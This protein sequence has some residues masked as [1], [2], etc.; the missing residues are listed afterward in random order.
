VKKNLKV[1][2]KN[3]QLAAAFNMGKKQ[4]KPKSGGQ[5]KGSASGFPRSS[6]SKHSGSQLSQ[7]EEPLHGKPSDVIPPCTQ[8]STQQGMQQQEKRNGP[9]PLPETTP[10][11]TGGLPGRPERSDI[12]SPKVESRAESG[13]GS[14]DGLR[15]DSGNRSEVGKRFSG[16]FG[17]DS[18]VA[19]RE[20]PRERQRMP[21]RGGVPQKRERRE[22]SGKATP[23]PFES[24]FKQRSGTLTPGRRDHQASSSFGG[25]N[26]NG[27]HFRERRV[28]ATGSPPDKVQSEQTG[29]EK[30]DPGRPKLGTIVRSAR[31][32]ANRAAAQK[33]VSGRGGRA[34]KI[35]PAQPGL[36][37]RPYPNK[38]GFKPGMPPGG[39]PVGHAN[40]RAGAR[41]D[42]RGGAKRGLFDEPNGSKSVGD[43]KKKGR[44][45][46]NWKMQ[47]MRHFRDFEDD[48]DSGFQKS[49]RRRKKNVPI[50]SAEQRVSRPQE[51][52]ISLPVS[53]KDLA[54]QMKVKASELISTLFLHG[55][56]YTINDS[57]H[58][59]LIVQFIGG[60]MNCDITIDTEKEEWMAI[61]KGSVKEE[62]R[63]TD[64]SM[65]EVRPAVVAMMGHVDHGK[66]TLI[67]ALRKSQI[68]QQEAGAITQHIGAFYVETGRGR[69]TV[70]DTPGHEAFIEMRS[71]GVLITDI[72]IL[73]IA[74]DEG[75]NQQTKEVIEKVKSSNIAC[76]VAVTKCDREGFDLN[77]IYE[78]LAQHELLVED[79]GGNILSV[80]CS[81]VTGEGL[82]QLV[83]AI[84]L[85]A[86]MLELLSQKDCRAR[87]IVFEAERDQGLGVCATLLVQNGTLRVRDS[88][89]VGQEWCRVKSMTSDTGVELGAAYPSMAVRVTGFSG[90][91]SVG[92]EFVAVSSVKEAKNISNA[93]RGEAAD[94]QLDRHQMRVLQDQGVKI[95]PLI[96]RGDVSGSVEAL[97][98]LI[99]EIPTEKVYAHIV[100]KGIGAISESD[101]ELAEIARA[102]II[103]FHVKCDHH[104]AKMAK[105]R[106]VDLHLYGI[107]YHAQDG[108]K[109]IM[110]S[111]LEPLRKETKT[112]VADVRRVFR[113]PKRGTVAGCVVRDGSVKRSS[114][115][116][117]FRKEEMLW[118]GKVLSMKREKEEISES[119]KGGECGILAEHFSN[120]EEG[121]V[122]E[123]YRETYEEQDL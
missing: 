5:D 105:E 123:A 56:S 39:R 98:H 14:K 101:I 37:R 106:E 3:T 59:P 13:T 78:Q 69:V 117:V 85:Q 53:V 40:V 47:S 29:Q 84:G 83:E 16:D 81:G 19:R 67:D 71:R 12:A 17:R 30:E 43:N 113:I 51:I 77:R 8:Q 108:V 75:I 94:H 15:V 116:K 95:L 82:D 74:G 36:P 120:F 58:D 104:L 88:F 66:T 122:I 110:R 111:L 118:E 24:S 27:Q 86:E 103:G 31:E 10:E 44:S 38:G 79:W 55:E 119:S 57:I 4:G 121:D 28:F 6:V 33:Q 97:C 93:R 52:S 80:P 73:V 41:S 32:E 11:V 65:L 46:P 48:S 54:G 89:V 21:Q 34:P 64:R 20:D 87:G 91:P 2:I 35:S 76:V 23:S 18:S 26:L 1:H 50:P 70:I 109:T 72:V 7:A 102:R 42:P 99:K 25:Q 90:L 63:D 62:I 115:I 68:A 49:P 45:D 107:I 60:E 100:S 61:V 92:S 96:I 112:G 114:W 9:Q 22:A